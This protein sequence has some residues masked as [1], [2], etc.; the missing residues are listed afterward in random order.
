[1][2]AIPSFDMHEKLEERLESLLSRDQYETDLLPLPAA[3]S[4][5]GAAAKPYLTKC[6]LWEA[7]GPAY[8]LFEWIREHFGPGAYNILIRCK[9]KML[10][11]GRIDI[12][13]LARLY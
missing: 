6:R 9:G 13:G 8:Q 4:R 7:E 11:S 2:K 3:R 5:D 10:L 1:M 12:D